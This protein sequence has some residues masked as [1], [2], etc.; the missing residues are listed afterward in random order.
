[1]L[2][3]IV[4]WRDEKWIQNEAPCLTKYWFKASNLLEY[5]T[6]FFALVSLVTI[7]AIDRCVSFEVIIAV[8]T[9]ITV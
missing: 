5:P 8:I 2:V 3:N 6:K 1:M 9:R 4:K 7:L